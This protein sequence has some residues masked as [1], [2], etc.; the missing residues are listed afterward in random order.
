MAGRNSDGDWMLGL[1]K[2]AGKGKEPDL[3]LK[4]VKEGINVK[5]ERVGYGCGNIISVESFAM[6]VDGVI[7]K[8]K[9]SS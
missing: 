4:K 1:A 6:G 9:S 7:T 8:K 2:A 3:T 5:K